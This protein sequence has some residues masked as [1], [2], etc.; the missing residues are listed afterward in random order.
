MDVASQAR[1]PKLLI[2]SLT[3]VGFRCLPVICCW[4]YRRGKACDCYSAPFRRGGGIS[5]C[6]QTHKIESAS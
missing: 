6:S 2:F 5:V 4:S 1:T 3:A